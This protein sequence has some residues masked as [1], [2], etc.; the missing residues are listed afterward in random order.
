MI[1]AGRGCDRFPFV[2]S[3]GFYFSNWRGG[4]F[5]FAGA[6]LRLLE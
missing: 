1:D 3:I 2:I 6:R 4:N 5:F